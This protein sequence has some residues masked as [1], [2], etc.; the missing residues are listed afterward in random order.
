MKARN[1]PFLVLLVI[2]SA[3]QG[4]DYFWDA[5]GGAANVG[6]T[7][8]WSA[9]TGWRPVSITTGTPGP[10]VDGNRPVFG[11]TLGI[12]TLDQNV[13]ASGMSF[14][15]ANT[16]IRP[17][18]ANAITFSGG[19]ITATG[20]SGIDLTAP[21]AGSLIFNPTGGTVGSATTFFIKADNT[22]LTSVEVAALNS[23]NNMT[24]DSAGAFGPAAATVKFTKGAVNL[25]ALSTEAIGQVAA[26]GSGGNLSFNAWNTELAGG[27]IRGRAGSNT[28]NGPINLTANS[29]ILTRGVAGVKVTLSS[30]ATV[31]LNANTLQL[32]PTSS[33]DGLV[34]NG[35][36]TGTGG[37]IT[38]SNSALTGAGVVGATSSSTL[39]GTN[40]YTGPTAI[41]IGRLNLTGSLTSAI[42]LATG[43][44]LLGEGSTTGA[45]NFGTAPA[46][47]HDFFLD[48]STP[49][50]GAHFKAAS[51]DASNSVVTVKLSGPSG[52]VTDMVVMEST[53]GPIT[54]TLANFAFT[55]R[56]SLSFNPAG[57]Q[58][59][60]TYAPANLVWKGGDL[61]NPSFWD[62]STQNWLN[63][64]SPDAFQGLDL[65]L[66]ND[67]ASSFTVAAQGTSVEPGNMTFDNTANAYTLGGSPVVGLASLTKNGTAKL[68]ITNENT[69]SGG[70]TI[71]AGIVELGDGFNAT[72][73]LGAVVA[74]V[75]NNA[76]IEANY[77]LA[78]SLA[79][80]IDG[81]GTFTQ[82][83]TGTV[84]LTGTNNYAGD[85]IINL[86]STLQLG[87]NTANGSVAG[88][89]VNNGTLSLNRSSASVL[90][91]TV[92]GSGGISKPAGAVITLTGNNTFDG[93]VAVAGG[94]LAVGSNTALG[95]TTGATTV[96]GGRVE[97]ANGVT[98]TGESI[99]ITSSGVD[100]NGA[101]QAQA[102]A[103]ATWAGPVAFN[104]A[105]ARVG[106]GIG[107]KLILTGVI[108]NGTFTNLNVGAG[109]GGAGTVVVSGTSNTYTGLTNIIRGTLELGAN[110]ALPTGTTLDIDTSNAAENAT[111][112]LAGF[113]QTVAGLQRSNIPSGNTTGT[114][115]AFLTNSSLT[116]A[117][118]T[119]NQTVSTTYRGR[120]TGNL[121]LVQTGTGT[122]TLAGGLQFEHTGNTTVDGNLTVAAD[123]QLT[124]APGTNT[125]TNSIQG[126]G[127]LILDGKIFLN[128]ATTDTTHGNSWTLVNTATLATED[129]DAVTFA[130]DSTLG[131]FTEVVA[132]PGTWKRVAAGN[133][134]TFVESTGLLSVGPV[135]DPFVAWI[136][137]FFTGETNPAI[138]GKTADPD[139][140]GV[141]NLTEFAL[142]GNPNSG[143]NNGLTA[144]LIQDASAPAGNEL[145][146]VAAIRD[147]AVFAP[148]AN[149][150]Q[151]ATVD[152]VVYTIQGSLA[153]TFPDSPVSV[154]GASD[155]APA[156]TGLPSLAT[157]PWEYRTFKLDASE[158][159]PGKGFLRV[160]IEVAP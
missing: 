101:L 125:V 102:A 152:G 59:L 47:T 108:A 21:L 111:V 88:N 154:G 43:T 146:L 57:T 156:A 44:G 89:I 134:W 81:T 15:V 49:A 126:T 98:V 138:I 68:T 135:S 120:I 93:P 147:G 20:I 73:N 5:N 66:F 46:S 58:L 155:T 30:T 86:G 33:S 84:N 124:L 34:L 110:N 127:N 28:L 121:A 18:G 60:F 151:T 64:G 107:G 158:G 132:T 145:T 112:D 122:L 22:G 16:E 103:T 150:V 37:G 26:N 113:N 85:T 78:K 106:T 95:T 141:D 8:N 65:V 144:V 76:A 133:E 50:P 10:W 104:S 117:T 140:D 55:G 2:A 3:S 116:P 54:G 99:T 41:N 97:L 19:T 114:G 137:S 160:K 52:A 153:L 11:T 123:S 38:Q 79:Y 4:A 94:A 24:I 157:T 118:F 67:T 90:A 9:A 27:S 131:A 69:F 139:N 105:D 142:N 128:L 92:S 14:T 143:S 13:A 35:N 40:T 82:K 74:P 149:G 45:L 80:N 75:T 53:G 115:T 7:G 23:D 96:T 25:G 136:D 63:S 119:V 6:G 36:I 42:T 51:I 31:N 159:L 109:S 70:T 29:N 71:N 83:G 39:A 87:N 17:S 61:T 129:Y 56:G 130:V 12:V 100:F 148:G 91:N 1:N 62:L 77:G 72:G 32:S 48:P